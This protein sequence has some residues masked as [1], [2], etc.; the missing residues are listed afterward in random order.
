MSHQRMGDHSQVRV[1]PTCSFMNIGVNYAGSFFIRSAKGRDH[2]T[3]NAYCVLFV[4][5]TT[6]VIHLEVAN[7]YISSGFLA[8]PGPKD[9]L[10]GEDYLQ[11]I[12]SDNGT[13]MAT[14]N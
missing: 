2:K 7:G 4:W 3:H 6:H 8:T 5:L 9:L 10:P 1:R 11:V 14:R 13:K 12:Y